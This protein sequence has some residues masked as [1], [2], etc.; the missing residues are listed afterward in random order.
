MSQFPVNPHRLDPYKNFKFRV[1]VGGRV[2][3]GVSKVSALKRSTM[4]IEHRDGGS[5]S[6]SLLSPSTWA[7]EPITLERG[8]THD[9]EF[10]EWSNLSFSV[11]GDAQMSLKNFRKDIV[12]N[13]LNAQDV[14][15]KA[16][17]VYRCWVSEYQV[18]P[19]LDANGD[20][21]AIESIVLQN[22]G[23]ERDDAV[24]ESDET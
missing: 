20:A 11:S 21:I 7:F 18:L 5:N 2:V 6:H 19:E 24:V 3:A 12:I 13:L 4:P 16:F 8:I 10:E 23:W 22:E 15:V 17:K 9:T 1:I 14:V